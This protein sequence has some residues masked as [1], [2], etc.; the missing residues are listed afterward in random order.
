M[1]KKKAIKTAPERIW[2]QI[3]DDLNDFNEAFPPSREG[4]TWCEDQVQNC[5]VEY[6]RAD[7]AQT[8]GEK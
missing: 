8:K 5:E 3:S 4:I 7:L 2:L 6:I 1:G